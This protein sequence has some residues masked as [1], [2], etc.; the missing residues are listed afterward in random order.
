MASPVTLVVGFRGCVPY[1]CQL[2]LFSIFLDAALV[3]PPR[4]RFVCDLA[5]PFYFEDVSETFVYEC[6]ELS[7]CCL[8]YS[9]CF[10]VVVLV[11][12]HVFWL[13]SWLLS[14]FSGCCL[15]YYPCCLVVV[16]V[17]QR[18]RATHV[19]VFLLEI[20]NKNVGTTQVIKSP[21]IFIS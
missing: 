1:P 4:E 21:F 20:P 13:L 6:L 12:L 14:M 10:L 17:S 15:G 18:H 11:T 2:P 5:L 8:G 16:F 7:C 19:S 3:C 9:P